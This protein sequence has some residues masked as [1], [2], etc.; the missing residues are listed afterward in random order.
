MDCSLPGSSVHGI[1][2][3]SV[4]EC[5]CLL[6]KIPILS[7]KCKVSTGKY[8]WRKKEQKKNWKDQFFTGENS[9]NGNSWF[10]IGS[11]S[12]L[13]VGFSFCT[14]S[15]RVYELQFNLNSKM[16]THLPPI[17]FWISW[18]LDEKWGGQEY[19][20]YSLV[21]FLLP[22]LQNFDSLVSLQ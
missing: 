20:D 16:W 12:K 8:V 5:H 4:L 1:C 18:L 11:K 19:S 17:D 13:K 9:S 2:Q 14:N 6:Q 15:I 21:L 22:T 10:G 7:W 3:A